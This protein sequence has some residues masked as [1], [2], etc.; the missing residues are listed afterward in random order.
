MKVGLVGYGYWG[1]IIRTYID[2]NDNF[3]LIKIYTLEKARWLLC[4]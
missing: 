3:E 4:K 1:K 2:K